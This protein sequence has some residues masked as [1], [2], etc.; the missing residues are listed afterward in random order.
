MQDLA[1]RV[2]QD[3]IADLTT[4]SYRPMYSEVEVERIERVHRDGV[5]ERAIGVDGD[6]RND[7]G[8]N[9]DDETVRR[10]DELVGGSGGDG[11]DSSNVGDST[12]DEV[13]ILVSASVA[14]PSFTGRKIPFPNVATEAGKRNGH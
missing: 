9:S 5:E 12:G 14:Y 13:G 4:E 7:I 8:D 6:N 2:R 11:D 10:I 3:N 1:N